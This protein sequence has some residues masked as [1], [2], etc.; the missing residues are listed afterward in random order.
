MIPVAD[1]SDGDELTRER[2]KSWVR[3]I[4]EL[5]GAIIKSVQYPLT[6]SA[7]V[8]AAV[9][10]DAVAWGSATADWSSGNIVYLHP[11][12]PD[13]GNANTDIAITG[14]LVCP[15]GASPAGVQVSAGNVLAY[16]PITDDSG[17]IVNAQM[18]GLPD[19]SGKLKYMV[20]QISDNVLDSYGSPA[21]NDPT[22]WAIDW[23][24]AH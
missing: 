20:L 7:G 18:G 8:L 1:F 15:T 3:A 12:D 14:Y 10:K 24:R 4:K 9:L 16:L 6:L 13:G 2:I 5:Q 19:N 11:C 23:V 21:P 22:K 17:L